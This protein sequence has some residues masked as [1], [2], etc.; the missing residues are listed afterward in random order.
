[1]NKWKKSVKKKKL[2]RR[3]YDLYG[4]KFSNMS[5]LLSIN[6]THLQIVDIGLREVGKNTVKRGE[7]VWQTDKH[8]NTQTYIR[9]FWLIKRI[10]PEGRF[11]ENRIFRFL[12]ITW[13][14]ISGKKFSGLAQTVCKKGHP[15]KR[16]PQCS[17]L[18]A[19]HAWYLLK[20]DALHDELWKKHPLVPLIR[21]F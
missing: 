9:T 6:F 8:T 12:L 18:P 4:Q 20:L 1:M 3:S 10:N 7:K 15:C 11:F 5:P 17:S 16:S 13:Q 21:S 2:Q 19:L 14:Y